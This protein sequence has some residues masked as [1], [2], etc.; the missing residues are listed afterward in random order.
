MVYAQMA[1]LADA[2]DSKSRARKGFR[3]RPSVWALAGSGE[4]VSTIIEKLHMWS[5]AAIDSDVPCECDDRGTESSLTRGKRF[6]QRCYFEVILLFPNQTGVGM[7]SV[8]SMV[9]FATRFV[10]CTLAI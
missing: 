8:R 2:R 4:A 10:A 1:E 5:K 6:T 9:S 3:V 7:R